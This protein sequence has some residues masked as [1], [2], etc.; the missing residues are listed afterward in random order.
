MTFSATSK[1]K[2]GKE[3]MEKYGK[4]FFH[5]LNPFLIQQNFL[6]L[7]LKSSKFTFVIQIYKQ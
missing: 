5:I 1:L 6:T 4:N 7:G 2:I 3:G